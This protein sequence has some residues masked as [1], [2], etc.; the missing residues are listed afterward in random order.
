MYR[1]FDA[2]RWR[3]F[4]GITERTIRCISICA[5]NVDDD[6]AI[7]AFAPL[8]ET[9]PPDE[10]KLRKAWSHAPIY[11]ARAADVQLILANVAGQKSLA[12]VGEPK[13]R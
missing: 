11:K 12:D 4:V 7:I 8:D 5:P 13:T 6:C 1:V 9:T 3:Q 10:T 2:F